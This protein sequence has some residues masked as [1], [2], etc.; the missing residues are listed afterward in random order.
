MNKKNIHNNNNENEFQ[1][2]LKGTYV[3]SMERYEII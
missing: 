1:W 2:E 3:R